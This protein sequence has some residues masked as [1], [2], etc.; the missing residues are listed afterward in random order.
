MYKNMS[1]ISYSHQILMCRLSLQSLPRW[2]SAADLLIVPVLGSERRAALK[3]LV[4]LDHGQRPNRLLH[5]MNTS[6]TKVL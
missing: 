2:I 3:F 5:P 6:E 1:S 4:L